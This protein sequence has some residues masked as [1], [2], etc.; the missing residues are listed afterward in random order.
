VQLISADKAGNE[1]T[2]AEIKAKVG[3][4]DVVIANAGESSRYIIW[5]AGNRPLSGTQESV[6][7]LVQALRLRHKNSPATLK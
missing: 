2:V 4:L 1:K 6:T 7:G 3:R 5:K